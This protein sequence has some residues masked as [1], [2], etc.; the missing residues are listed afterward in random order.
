MNRRTFLI[1]IG[2]AVLAV[3]FTAE[4]QPAGKVYKVGLF[5][6]GLTTSLT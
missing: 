4:A 5:Q 1:T 3:P 2:V 6:V